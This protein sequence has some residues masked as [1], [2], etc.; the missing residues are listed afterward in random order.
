MIEREVEMNPHR[1]YKIH[2]SEKIG[3]TPLLRDFSWL[4]ATPWWEET[5]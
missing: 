3:Q 4:Q 2:P 5:P 1:L